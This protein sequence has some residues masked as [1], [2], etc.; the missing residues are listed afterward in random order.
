[1]LVSYNWL[2]EEYFKDKLPD[3]EDLVAVLT[4]HAFEI[5]SIEKKGDD[6]L[7]D[8]DVLPN[9]AH[10]CL[11]HKGIACEIGVILEK[12][13]FEKEIVQPKESPKLEGKLK[14][15]VKEPKLCPRYIGRY[16]SNIKVAESP[17]WLHNRIESLGQR[18]INNLVD[19]TNYV[20]FDLGQPL[21]VFDADKLEGGEIVVRRARKGE[22]ITTLDGEDIELDE[23]ILVIADG[24]DPIAI[25]GVKGG[26][27]AEV[28]ENTKNIVIESANFAYA[29]I[30]KTSH[31]V[32]IRTEASNR[33]EHEITS[34]LALQGMDLATAL[35][36]EIAGGDD[37]EVG[38]R[39]DEY[40]KPEKEC[41]VKVTLGKINSVLGAKLSLKQVEDILKRFG[42]D[43]GSKNSADDTKFNIIIPQE[44]LD[45]RIVEDIVEEIGRVYGY[46]NIPEALPGDMDF[47]PKVNKLFYYIGAIRN[48]LID[49]GFSEVETYTF[50]D[51]G[52]V[53][54]ENP[55]A[56]DKNFVRVELS[57]KLS[58][59]LELNAKNVD[60][61]GVDNVKIFEIGTVF[62]K[63]GEYT[64]LGIAFRN[65]KVK[66]SKA[67]EKEFVEDVLKNLSDKFK[68][69]FSS[70]ITELENGGA[71]V[72][73]NL[74][75]L[76]E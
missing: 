72:E 29:N 45:L 6:Y 32:G 16:V 22:H 1:M 51:N 34:E 5:E 63:G 40:A 42:F 18:S 25:A 73:M 20:L 70:K 61:V 66:K 49:E 13:F 53:E 75:K 30:R 26:T 74:D 71:V 55:L 47:S 76:V 12:E 9:R 46:D 37:T 21:H 52:E 44:R 19:I 28:D 41:S 38:S 10:D 4:H 62:E 27:K 54:I 8:V 24:K 60:L 3:P 23:T 31:K 48:T 39:K 17:E 43:F 15:T 56:I 58:L 33:Y 64:S 65:P 57:E 67:K 69:P 35:V 50:T 7:I 68:V 2:Q 36:V 14:V 59:A 11:S